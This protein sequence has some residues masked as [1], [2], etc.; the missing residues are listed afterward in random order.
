MKT[1]TLAFFVLA[2]VFTSPMSAMATD[3]VSFRFT[4]H[5]VLIVDDIQECSVP[6]PEPGSISI[7]DPVSG[8]FTYDLDATDTN[9]SASI[10]SY[11]DTSPPP[12]PFYTT[13]NGLTFQPG[14]ADA[15]SYVDTAWST[16][17][18]S[19]LVGSGGS[20]ELIPASDLGLDGPDISLLYLQLGSFL[21]DNIGTALSDDS[22]PSSLHLDD[23]ESYCVVQISFD[24]SGNTYPYYCYE[25]YTKIVYFLDTLDL[26]LDNETDLCSNGIDDDCD[27]LTDSDDADCATTPCVGCEINK[28]VSIGN[29]V[30]LGDYVIVNKNASIGDN[31]EVG[32]GTVINQNVTIG[33]D[34]VIGSNVAIGR[35][36]NMGS[37]V[38]IGNNTFI[39]K[40][41][42]IGNDVMIGEDVTIGRDAVILGGA[43]IPDG[44]VIG[45]R[46]TVNP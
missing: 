11:M 6:L 22:L 5:V 23:F 38:Q 18:S 34:V 7:D 28:G 8:V 24:D 1:R 17:S 15:L 3:L 40:G 25:V 41:V 33:D 12:S 27:G 35:D 14:P 10:G 2:V 13:I 46:A 30:Q 44:T 36:V 31:V 29:D 43:V 19:I 39:N 4:G 45:Q 42:T 20:P 32:D 37:D 16:V 21:Y 26:C 9:S